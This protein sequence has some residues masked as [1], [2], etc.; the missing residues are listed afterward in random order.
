MIDSLGSHLRKQ[1]M[2]SYQVVVSNGGDRCW[3]VEWDIA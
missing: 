1:T 2:M 3:R